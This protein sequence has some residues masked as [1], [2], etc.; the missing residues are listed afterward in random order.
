VHQ[1]TLDLET[2]RGQMAGHLAARGLREVMTP[3]LTSGERMLR[4]GVEDL[5]HLQNP[6]S[7][8][9]DVLRPTM[10][11]GMLQAVAHNINRQ[12]RDLRFF[13]RGRTYRRKG[14]SARETD[15]LALLLTGN[16]SRESWRM[17]QRR[18]GLLDLKEELEALLRRMGLHGIAEWQPI[19]DGRMDQ[20]H[21][22][23]VK[24]R[25]AGV[26]GEVSRA[27]LKQFDLSQPVFFAELDEHVLL[28]AC[29]SR[30]IGSS[31]IPRFPVVRRDLSLLLDADMRFDRLRTLALKAERKL[32][33][34]V[35]LFDVYQGDKLPAGKKS[36]AL[37]FMLQDEERTLTDEVV[38]KAMGRIRQALEKEA[39]AVLRA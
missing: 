34:E 22:L 29:R 35:D 30:P 15:M 33:R 6:L 31:D 18:A 26:L 1:T 24:G 36:Y 14:G 23:L 27:L 11:A 8:E 19:G 17:P 10:L 28:E 13:E 25:A 21:E 4:N 20:A 37:S 39:G 7:T 5:V 9:L 32:L 12:Q 2:L 38:E 16:A 3:S